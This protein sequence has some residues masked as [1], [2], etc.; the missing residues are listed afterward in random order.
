MILLATAFAGCE[1][2][3]FDETA[4]NETGAEKSQLMLKGALISGDKIYVQ[5]DVVTSVQLVSTN[6]NNPLTS[7]TWTIENTNYNGLN[8]SHKFSNLGDVVV[9]VVA[10]FQSGTTET[11]D[12]TLTVTKDM[13]AYDPVKVYV[14]GSSIISGGTWNGYTRYAVIMLIS[15]ER[16]TNKTMYGY[17][18][19]FNDDNQANWLAGVKVPTIEANYIIVNGVPTQVTNDIGKYFAIKLNLI[20]REYQGAVGEFEKSDGT[21]SFSWLDLSGS[22]YVKASENIGIFKF[23][24]NSNGTITPLGDGYVP[25]TDNVPGTA[26]DIG[27]GIFRHELVGGKLIVYF[28]LSQAFSNLTPFMSIKNQETGVWGTPIALTAV[29]NYSNYGKAELLETQVINNLTSLRF[30]NVKSN[31]AFDFS[32]MEKS[33]YYSQEFKEIRF[34]ILKQ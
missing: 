30:G 6:T 19:N 29:S 5:K 27:E 16:A 11:R 4:Q 8:V 12:F 3:E 15:K 2:V 24:M 17:S 32:Q 33:L 26:G 20:A 7:A 34:T 25:T 28:R 10:T 23:R 22:A 31:G 21:G 18:G 13:S 9:H 14:T 1:Y